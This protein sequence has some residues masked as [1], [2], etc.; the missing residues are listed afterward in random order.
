MCATSNYQVNKTKHL[1]WL[2]KAMAMTAT[3][4]LKNP[5]AVLCYCFSKYRL[6]YLFSD[7]N[8][9]INRGTE[10]CVY[11]KQ[12][13]SDPVHSRLSQVLRIQSPRIV[14][15]VKS[16]AGNKSHNSVVSK[17]LMCIPI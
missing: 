11:E 5:P 13:Q 9:F 1:E 16:L 2:E 7:Q 6:C 8:G 12:H 4:H 15:S 10:T 17:R 14:F 3:S